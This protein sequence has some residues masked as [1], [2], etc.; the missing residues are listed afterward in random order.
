MA[1]K[2]G[3]E[4][5]KTI[6]RYTRWLTIVLAYDSGDVDGDRD[7]PR[8]RVLRLRRGSSSLY[9]VIAM[10]AG[11]M[12][13]MWLGEQ[14]TDKGIGNGVSLIIFIGIVLRFPTHVAQTF[15]LGQQ[16]Q[17]QL[18][19]PAAV[20][21]RSRWSRSSRS[22][23]C[24]RA[25]AA[26][27][28]SKRAASSAARCSPA[29]RATF[30]CAST[31]PASSRSSSRSRSCCCR[32]R[33]SRGSAARAADTHS[34]AGTISFYVPDATSGPNSFLYN[35]VYFLLVVIFTFFY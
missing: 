9:A 7:E 18:A 5:R 4:G 35:L 22:S 24:T 21:R 29:A 32:S 33:R 14:I 34:V 31:T 11:T 19:R 30:R 26:S 13:L 23:S 17:R 16:G 27:R 25:S 15:S 20:H 6:S 10:V 3:E 12:F 28:C 1:K 8:R 2:G